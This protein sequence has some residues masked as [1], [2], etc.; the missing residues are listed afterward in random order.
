[1]NAIETEEA[2]SLALFILGGQV[3]EVCRKPTRNFVCSQC[4]H[5]YCPFCGKLA[6]SKED[7]RHLVLY[8]STIQD[9]HSEFPEYDGWHRPFLPNSGDQCWTKEQWEQEFG[10]LL[11][12]TIRRSFFGQPTDAMDIM[13][14]AGESGLLPTRTLFTHRRI[15][16]SGFPPIDAR[17]PVV[18]SREPDQFH[19]LFR[20][21]MAQLDAAYARLAA[22]PSHPHVTR[23]LFASMYLPSNLHRANGCGVGDCRARHCP[24]CTE[25]SQKCPHLIASWNSEQGAGFSSRIPGLTGMPFPE[26]REGTDKSHQQRAVFGRLIQTL[27]TPVFSLERPGF[28]IEGQTESYMVVD[29]YT[30]HSV[31]A[32]A[33]IAEALSRQNKFVVE[34]TADTAATQG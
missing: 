30:T 20:I 12:L 22:L 27:R 10:S 2:V 23:P 8:S 15:K 21:L 28:R 11:P 29:Y 25:H 5:C 1:M 33:E 4:S 3:C 7:C 34:R 17:V 19:A 26:C 18:F 32:C 14:L 9:V 6:R 31:K 24:F 13:R 16:P